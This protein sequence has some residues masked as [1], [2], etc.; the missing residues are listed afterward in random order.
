MEASSKRVG[1]KST[2]FEEELGPFVV[3]LAFE[4]ALVEAWLACEDEDELF[5][6][7]L[8]TLEVFASFCPPDGVCTD[9]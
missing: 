5:T 1:S 9:A 3:E 4:V 6:V 7:A 8:C 2:S